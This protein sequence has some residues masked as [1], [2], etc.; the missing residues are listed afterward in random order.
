MRLTQPRFRYLPVSCGPRHR[1]APLS[2]SRALFCMV[3]LGFAMGNAGRVLALEGDQEQPIFVEADSVEIDD[4]Q[5]LSV[6]IGN[7]QIDQGS[8]RIL[9]DHVTVQHSEDRRPQFITALGN[10][11]RYRQDVEGENGEVNAHALRMEYDALK[12][13]LVLIDQAELTQAADRFSSE[14]IVY[15][16]AHARVKAGASAQGAGRVKITIT[17]EKKPEAPAV[18]KPSPG[19][20]A[21]QK[22]GAKGGGRPPAAGAGPGKASGG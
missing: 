1:G 10:P 19:P 3:L 14:R 2:L 15:D 7:V 6:Y 13:E 21:G 18:Q 16:R 4:I 20:K 5:N 9:A 11:V 12:D 22:G 17:P 8:M